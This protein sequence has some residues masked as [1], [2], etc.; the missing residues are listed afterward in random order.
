MRTRRF[1][2]LLVGGCYHLINDCCSCHNR[3]RTIKSKIDGQPIRIKKNVIV[4]VSSF[5]L[6]V[7]CF[8]MCVEQAIK[9]EAIRLTIKDFFSLSFFRFDIYFILAKRFWCL[10]DQNEYCKP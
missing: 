3:M 2:T 5:D 9:I 8:F 4:A 6:S 1:D 10:R 7:A